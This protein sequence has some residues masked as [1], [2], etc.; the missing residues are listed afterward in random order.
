MKF[1]FRLYTSM[2]F[3][4]IRKDRLKIVNQ[5]MKKTLFDWI[6]HHFTMYLNKMCLFLNNEYDIVVII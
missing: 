6:N 2:I 4:I 5:I 1:N 3:S